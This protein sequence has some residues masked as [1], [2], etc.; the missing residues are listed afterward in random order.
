MKRLEALARATEVV[1]SI[2][3]NPE[4]NNRGYKVDGWKTPTLAE[5]TEAILKLAEFLM[6]EDQPPT[7]LVPPMKTMVTI[8]GWDINSDGPPSKQAYQSARATLATW[9][10]NPEIT[11]PPEQLQG[12]EELIRVYEQHSPESTAGDPPQDT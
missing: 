2:G 3:N 9:R 11:Y 6:T 8:F 7:R 1:E 5:R 10:R 12:I 4:K